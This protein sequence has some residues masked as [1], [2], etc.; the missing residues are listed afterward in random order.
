M[1][2]DHEMR[3]AFTL[4]E[5]AK[6]L[7]LDPSVTTLG[8]ITNVLKNHPNT[9]DIIKQ[10]RT[11]EGGI[12]YEYQFGC[13]CWWLGKC[14]HIQF[15]DPQPEFPYLSRMENIKYPDI[16]AVFSLK[17]STFPC[18]I[19]VKSCNER[20][21]TMSKNY[22]NGLKKHPLAQNH[23]ILIAWKYKEF[24]TLFDIDVFK[25]ENGGIKVKFED[26]MTANLMGI[27]AGDFSFKGFKQGI[28]WSYT[29]EPLDSEICD[30]QSGKIKKF[31][32]KF[33][34]ISVSDPSTNNSMKISGPLFYL[35]SFLGEW[36]PFEK[37]TT[38][39]IISGEKNQFQ[40]SIFAYQ[41]LIFGTQFRANITRKNV[42]WKDILRRQ[43]FILRADELYSLIHSGQKKKMGFEY[44]PLKYVPS[45]NNPCL[46]GLV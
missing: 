32:G 43:N 19:Q 14:I 36:I 38:S 24:W 8:E 10:V 26:A 45:I 44:S 18:F 39:H 16:F 22:V 35:L 15:I 21:L 33:I 5:L 1:V 46:E 7:D 29:I 25:T 4:R 31:I 28:E 17:E 12:P 3:M 27:L 41:A 6:E 2:K 13:I 23:P 34:D 42:D 40:T 20:M 11:Q 9:E 37:Y 30:I